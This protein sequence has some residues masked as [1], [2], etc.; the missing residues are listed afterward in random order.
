MESAR[1]SECVDMCSSL[2]RV[3]GFP[4]TDMRGPL[5]SL[6]RLNASLQKQTMERSKV[7]VSSLY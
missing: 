1:R 2:H 5:A 7:Q 3:E 4:Q 6:I